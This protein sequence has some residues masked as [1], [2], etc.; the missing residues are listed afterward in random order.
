MSPDLIPSLSLGTAAL[1]LFVLC[2]GFVMLRGLARMIVGTLTLGISAWVGFRVWQAAP[3]LSFEWLGQSQ[4]WITNGLPVLAFVL[5]FFLLR[6]ITNFFTSPFGGGSGS[7]GPRTLAGT[8]FRLVFAL[9]PASLLWIIGAALVHHAGSIAELKASSGKGKPEQ[10][11]VQKLKSTLES[12]LPADW[13]AALDPLA[14]P[15]RLSL[16][17]LIAAQSSPEFAPEIDPATGKPIP[18]AILVEDPALQ[19][20]AREGNF[21]TLLRHPLLTKALADPKIQQRLRDLAQ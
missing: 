13:L 19:T 11:F 20:L 3:A 17:K 14:D 4:P 16:A 15:S 2:A 8:V 18:R 21:S 7:S 1:V 5:V 6:K 9:I 12:T 10:G